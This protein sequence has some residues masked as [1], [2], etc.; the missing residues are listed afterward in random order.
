[1]FRFRRLGRAVL[2]SL[3][4]LL[5]A[6]TLTGC[7]DKASCTYDLDNG[8]RVKVVFRQDD[9]FR[10]VEEDPFL[11]VREQE[12]ADA[13][14]NTVARG[15]F[16]TKQMASEYTASIEN[17]SE[18]VM[19]DEG[20]TSYGAPYFSFTYK[21]VFS[22]VISIPDSD[23]AVLV[24]SDRSADDVKAVFERIT[25]KLIGKNE[26]GQVLSTASKSS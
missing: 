5:L 14:D 19:T 18:A 2:L 22:C 24:T 23:S 20:I 16:I 6:A 21:G 12:G 7:R 9:G 25:V 8:D 4:T 17:D 1:M 26:S 10:F 15:V 13:S 11:V 3:M